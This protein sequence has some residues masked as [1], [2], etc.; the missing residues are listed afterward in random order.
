MAGILAHG[1]RND[2][3]GEVGRAAVARDPFGPNDA[4]SNMFLQR[5][6]GNVCVVVYLP[7]WWQSHGK[8][9]LVRPNVGVYC[10][11]TGAGAI[12]FANV[13]PYI[14]TVIPMSC[15]SAIWMRYPFG[16]HFSRAMRLGSNPDGCEYGALLGP[17]HRTRWFSVRG[18][19]LTHQDCLPP[20]DGVLIIR[21]RTLDVHYQYLPIVANIDAPQQGVKNDA[22]PDWLMGSCTLKDDDAAALV[23]AEADAIELGQHHSRL[24]SLTHLKIQEACR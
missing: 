4:L 16:D 15:V 12:L 21:G 23:A 2:V 24:N 6:R 18:P 17:K 5:E 3:G 1:L 11:T 22:D 7:E 10:L 20:R 13:S 19:E 9:H 14:A 8:W